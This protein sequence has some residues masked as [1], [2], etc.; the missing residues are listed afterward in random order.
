MTYT[1]QDFSDFSMI[2]I[3]RME[4]ETQVTILNDNLLAVESQDQTDLVGIAPK[5]E[6]LMRSAHS[7]KGAARIVGLDLAVKVAHAME[8]CF[9]AAQTGQV[10]LES[11]A[12]D[13]LLRGIDW[14]DQ[15][16]LRLVLSLF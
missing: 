14:Y 12:I 10:K 7:M 2:D 16:R 3:F 8:D 4:V 9:V 11:Q 15:L 5:L 1:P 13:I 6:A